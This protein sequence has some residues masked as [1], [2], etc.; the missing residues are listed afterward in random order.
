[1]DNK[2]NYRSLI[3]IVLM[4][5][6]CYLWQNQ[7]KRERGSGP[8]RVQTEKRNVAAQSQ[9][10]DHL[11]RDTVKHIGHADEVAG[12]GTAGTTVLENDSLKLVIDNKG[13]W[14]KQVII[15]GYRPYAA[16]EAGRDAPLYMVNDGNAS[17][18]LTF[19]DK[20]GRSVS[21]ENR[22]FIPILQER[23]GNQV[24]RMRLQLT[25]GEHLDYIYTLK[26][27]YMMDFSIQSEGM[28]DAWQETT[29]IRLDWRTQSFSREKSPGME[30]MGNE[31]YYT[32]E[33]GRTDY[34]R[35]DESKGKTE[36]EV[37]WIASHQGFFTAIL[38]P[39]KN[40]KTATFFLQS[41]SGDSTFVKRYRAV[42]PLPLT[43][44][45]LS[46]QM[47][48]YY[49]PVKY[50]ILQQYN[51]KLEAQV[52]FGWGIFRYVNIYFINPVFQFFHNCG[53]GFGL[54]IFLMTMVMKIVLSPV[55]Y[56]Q[57]LQSAKMRIIRP[58]IQAIN[59]KHKDSP[60]KRQME[61]MRVQN[62]A[63]A[64]MLSGCLPALFQMP[65]LYAMFRFYPALIDLRQQQFLWA[66][67][68]TAYD[69]V[70]KL[71]F[72]IPI[73][74][75]HISLFTILMAI[76]L[77]FYTRVNGMGAM[78][79]PAQKGM[80]NMK[81]MIYLMPVF[82]L[83]F[84]NNYASGL[85]Y[86]YFVANLTTVILIWVIK[87]FIL[88]DERIHAKIQASKAKPKKKGT[89]SKKMEEMMRQAQEQQARNRQ[90]KMR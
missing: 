29:P 69:S 59:E 36:R 6:L 86:Y 47:N 28:R 3:G 83:L 53:L 64:G 20:S 34:M 66:D 44:G 62:E 12:G 56:R 42:A 70:L 82:M 76:S 40:F 75:D 16:Y 22:F 35:S 10:A 11:A 4:L 25:G 52:Q 8:T 85:T 87:R 46:C 72:Q 27:D 19:V 43:D 77:L 17:F 67:D 68:L 50:E 81:F 54:I 74:G 38:L 78:Q 73:Y 18:G 32:Y 51:R 88:D 13:G 48:W 9:M 49:G 41:E 79:Q 5:V 60:H 24:L 26:D 61:T 71:P 15:K 57:Y 90:R 58:E 14:F 80:P 33:N 30:A 1:M 89:F 2:P 45:E 55:T 39:G 23:D 37:G 31:F 63:G 21:T 7:I 84:F 65:I